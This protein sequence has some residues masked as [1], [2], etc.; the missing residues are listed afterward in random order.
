MTDFFVVTMRSLSFIVIA[1]VAVTFGTAAGT[2]SEGEKIVE[3]ARGMIGKYPYAW[4]GGNDF[5]P[6]KGCSLKVKP[7]NDTQIVGFDC[8]GLAKYS[9]YQGVNI[10]MRHRAQYQYDDCPN[11]VN[12]SE[13]DAGD[14]VFFGADFQN[15]THVAIYAGDNQII[16]ASGHFENCTGKLI[17]QRKLS[18]KTLL[19]TACRMWKPDQRSEVNSNSS[20]SSK[21]TRMSVSFFVLLF[22]F[23]IVFFITGKDW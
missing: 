14:L 22:S 8:S 2:S 23:V 7:C 1:V 12:I 16:E 21:S 6:T 3:A 18:G 20:Q 13:I 10:S 4:C 17:L 15:I 9:V 19:S 11:Y 5:G